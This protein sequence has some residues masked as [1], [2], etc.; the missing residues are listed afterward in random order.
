MKLLVLVVLL[1][2]IGM[3]GQLPAHPAMAAPQSQPFDL[4][5]ALD[6][7]EI[8]DTITVP[9]GTY[10]GPLR[11]DTAGVTLEGQGWPVID[12]GGLGDVLTVSAPD[13][14]VRGLVLRHS[15][16][17]LDR[18][19]AGIT[20]LAPRL[21]FENNR[22]EDVLFGIYLKEAPDS[23]VRGNEVTGM[24]LDIGRRGDGI[25]IWQSPRTLVEGN[26]VYDARDVVMWFSDDGVLRNNVVENGR[27]GLHF[28]FSNNQILEENILRGNSVGVYLMYG[29][30]LEMRNNLLLDN[31]GPSG[32]GAALKDVDDVVAQGNRMI[33]N[34]V[35]VYVDN[36]PREAASTVLFEDNLVAYNQIG[37]EMLPLVQRNTYT[38]NIF[39]EN[40]EQIAIAGGGELHNN[41][42]SREGWGNYWSDYAGYDADGNRVGDIAYQ[43][44]SLY[45]DLMEE[46]PELRLFQLSPATDALDLAA[47]AFPVFLPRAK[48]ADEH[49]LMAPPVLPD[50]PGLPEPP[51]LANSAA[52]LGMLGL[53][54][55]VL[56]LGS[57]KIKR[58]P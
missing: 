37:I 28:M 23:I 22:L 43:S 26:H 19:H 38:N 33:N 53:A 30:G 40:S 34:R 12:G 57:R 8:G 16:D 41:D 32:Y 52:A 55:A 5:A 39:Q 6:A 54:V 3:I 13:V 35:G 44:K 4:Q 47:K 27:Y 15:G 25:R 10:S 29:R 45:E 20:G 50:V 36:S 18:E 49:P 46:Y 31:N 7:A 1:T 2:S 9:P 24:D 42:W 51:V 21:T 58:N 14:T 17:S 56:F 48:M 11:L